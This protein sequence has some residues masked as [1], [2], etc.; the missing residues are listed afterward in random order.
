MWDKSATDELSL[1]SF[2]N[3][4]L[5]SA[6]F[7]RSIKMR[8]KMTLRVVWDKVHGFR[9]NTTMRFLREECPLMYIMKTSDRIS[10]VDRWSYYSPW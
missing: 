6:P 4:L 5:S 7:A 2:S 3:V 9:Q 8:K 10:R 1:L